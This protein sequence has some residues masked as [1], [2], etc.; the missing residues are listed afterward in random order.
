MQE[1][2][3]QRRIEDFV[4]DHCGTSIKGAGYTDHCSNCLWS[5]HVDINPGDR[6]E[7]CG[8][9]MDPIGVEDKSDGYIINYRCTKCGYKHKVKAVPE[10]N[11][12]E[13]LK[14]INPLIED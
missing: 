11:F 14:L 12:E 10:D 13:L 8:G 2:K 4:C 3:F 5:K 6:K 9:S 7:R 1:K